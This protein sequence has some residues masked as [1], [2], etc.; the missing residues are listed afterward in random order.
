VTALIPTSA[1]AQVLTTAT[2]VM[3]TQTTL[4]GKTLGPVDTAPFYAVPVSVGRDGHQ[5]RTRAPTAMDASCMS[6]VRPSRACSPPAT[7]WG[8]VTG[9]AYGGAGGNHR[10]GNGFRLSRG[11]RRGD[12]EVGRLAERLGD[13]RHVEVVAPDRNAVVAYLEDTHHR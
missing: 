7:R 10:S 12:R 1:V 11:L 9:R 8:G 3:S 5:G 4:A 6:A 2:G 13:S